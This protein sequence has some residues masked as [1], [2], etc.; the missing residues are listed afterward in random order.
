VGVGGGKRSF[1]KKPQRKRSWQ[2]KFARFDHDFRK[3]PTAETYYPPWPPLR[4]GVPSHQ[5]M[6]FVTAFK[7]L[8]TWQKAFVTKPGTS[9]KVVY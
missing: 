5:H 1:V 8:D 7:R 2:L 9:P 3:S 4:Y 6:T